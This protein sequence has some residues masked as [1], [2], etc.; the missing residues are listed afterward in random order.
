MY[1]ENCEVFDCSNTQSAYA[2]D[3]CGAFSNPT[4]RSVELVEYLYEAQWPCSDG[5]NLCGDGGRV[6]L[7]N[8]NFS[9]PSQFLKS[10][11][12]ISCYDLQYDALTGGL[13]QG[14]YCL[15]VPPLVD[16]LCGC[17]LPPTVAP[18]ESPTSG[19]PV[20]PPTLAPL[21]TAGAASTLTNPGVTIA[22]LLGA[23]AAVV[24]A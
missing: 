19:L 11:V 17:E 15:T 2:G 3:R 12:S 8:N 20:N 6:T 24:W 16:T 18:V 13:S 7:G 22:G 5:C 9:Y 10:N 14:D 23:V 21:P 4:L 1:G